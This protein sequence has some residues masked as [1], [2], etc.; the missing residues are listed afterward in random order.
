MGFLDGQ[1]DALDCPVRQDAK[2]GGSG[3]MA[4]RNFE[5]MTF[6][7][8]LK[9]KKLLKNINSFFSSN[10]ENWGIES[11]RQTALNCLLDYPS[12]AIVTVSPVATLSNRSNQISR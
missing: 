6:F 8:F 2:M 10:P 9:R 12:K 5:K 11:P 7:P 4:L 1:V 3:S